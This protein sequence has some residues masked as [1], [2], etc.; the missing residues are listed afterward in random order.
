MRNLYGRA[1]AYEHNYALPFYT[2]DSIY[3]YAK[4]LIPVAYL[5]MKTHRK[6][7]RIF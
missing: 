4:V 5:L 1:D 7:T 6:T 3:T 2:L